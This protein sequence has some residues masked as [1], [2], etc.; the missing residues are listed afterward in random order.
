M[1]QKIPVVPSVFW[2]AGTEARAIVLLFTLKI[3]LKQ[4]YVYTLFQN[5]KRSCSLFFTG[6]KYIVLTNFHLSYIENR[7]N[8]LTYVLSPGMLVSHL[9]TIIDQSIYQRMTVTISPWFN[10]AIILSVY[11]QSCGNEE[12]TRLITSSESCE[13]QILFK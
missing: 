1:L 10:K 7:V 3:K 5:L 9:K 4:K 8:K 2:L 12:L 11:Y 6:S 13:N